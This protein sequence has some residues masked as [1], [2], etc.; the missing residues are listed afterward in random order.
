[1]NSRQQTQREVTSWSKEIPTPIIGDVTSR[2]GIQALP[3]Y[4][5]PDKEN[6]AR[7][8]RQIIQTGIPHIEIGFPVMSGDP[9]TIAVRHVV[10]QTRDLAAGIFTLARLRKDDINQSITTLEGAKH[11]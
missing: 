3:W 10:E 7:F 1:M 8:A 2:D 5:F 4:H 11:P 9:E 6:R